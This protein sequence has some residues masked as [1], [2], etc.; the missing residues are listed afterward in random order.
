MPVLVNE[1]KSDVRAVAR[2]PTELDVQE[3]Q[4]FEA[5]GIFEWAGI[6]RMHDGQHRH[7]RAFHD[8]EVAFCAGA[9]CPKRLLVCLAFVSRQGGV[10]AVKFNNVQSFGGRF[11][12]SSKSQI[13]AHEAGSPIPRMPSRPIHSKSLCMRPPNSPFS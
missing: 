7:L 13:Q 4:G 8:A 5:P 3:R 1:L 2:H 12:T 6:Y 9:E 10:V 11:L